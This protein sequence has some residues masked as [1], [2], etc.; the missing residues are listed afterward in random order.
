[1]GDGRRRLLRNLW[2]SLAVLATLALIDLGLPAVNRRLPSERSVSALMPY[3]VAAGVTVRPPPGARVDVTQTQPG[4]DGG[5]VLF[6]VRAVRYAIVIVPFTGSLAT[7]AR[8]LR[9]KIADTRDY[10]VAGGER[11]V[12][13]AQGV[14]GREG[15]Y[16][17]AGRLGRYADFVAGGF[18]VQVTVAGG[19]PD[20]P[21]VLPAI[22]ASARTLTFRQAS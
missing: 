5:S 1:M 8:R 11:T 4:P 20:L 17:S 9:T 14:A 6:N 22:S 16:S 19:A 12:T 21:A 2:L 18:A 7:A 3:S 13:T 15:R 10:Q